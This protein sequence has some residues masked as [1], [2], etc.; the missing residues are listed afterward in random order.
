MCVCVGDKL[1][2]HDVSMSGKHSH[3]F[4]WQLPN[5]FTVKN[6]KNRI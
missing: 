3:G 1:V 5:H 2:V 6:K 4:T